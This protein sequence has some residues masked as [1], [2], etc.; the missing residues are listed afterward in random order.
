MVSHSSL[1]SNTAPLPLRLQGNVRKE[2]EIREDNR[3][4][5][6]N[7]VAICNTCDDMKV[8][9]NLYER[10]IPPIMGGV[11]RHKR[12]NGVNN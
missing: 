11:K 4:E 12:A 5:S 9:T 7:G 8:N 2:Y 6:K 1:C 3:K 10:N